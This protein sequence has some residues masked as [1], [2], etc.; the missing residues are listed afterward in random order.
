[1]TTA[2]NISKLIA[3]AKQGNW[4]AQ[5]ELY[6]Y[7]ADDMM[8]IAIRYSEDLSSAKDLVQDTFLKFFENIERFDI[9]KGM[10]GPWLSRILINRALQNIKKGK[11]MSFED[12]T[13]FGDE[14]Y[15][16]LSVLERLKAEDIIKLLDKIPEGCRAIFNLHVVEGYKHD[17]IG[18]MLGIT[19][20]ASR[21]QLTR[22]KKLLRNI[23]TKNKSAYKFL[24]A[25][26][27]SYKD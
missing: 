18:S 1:L 23:L 17:E 5:K 21:S 11:R 7:Y 25:A 27:T 22:A 12:D 13:F 2:N 3:E 6:L 24:N 15:I 20:G 4:L 9:L 14:P 26:N 16:E 8:S 19:A 10:P